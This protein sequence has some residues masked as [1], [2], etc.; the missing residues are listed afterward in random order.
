MNRQ[1]EIVNL[2]PVTVQDSTLQVVVNLNTAVPFMNHL[3]FAEQSG[4]SAGVV[5]GWLD[6]GYLP[7][8]KVG[9]YQ[10]INLV[11]LTENLKKGFVL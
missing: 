6:N 9:R 1:H 10:V 4:F 2:N 11:L 7:T 8:V 3:H 5:G